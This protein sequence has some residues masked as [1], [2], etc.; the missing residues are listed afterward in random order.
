M[1]LWQAGGRLWSA[2]DEGSVRE[3][4]MRALELGLNR[5]D[6]A[7]IYGWGRSERLLGSIIGNID[8]VFI[9]SKVGGFRRSENDIVKAAEKIKKRLGRDSVDLLLSHWPP[10]FYADICRVI[11]GLEKAVDKGYARSIGVSNYPYS[12]LEKAV[13]CTRK[14][15][16]K[17]DQVQYSLAYRTPELAIIPR[18]K[19]LNITVMAWSPLAKGAL[20]ASTR[21]REPARMS[22][23]VYRKVAND[24]CLHTV[25]E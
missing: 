20:V 19:E 22:D 18:A 17:T 6:T 8:E 9:V 10:P 23:P 25:L 5:F 15:E 13:Y 1:G 21:R 2:T 16:V 7:E 4:I 3:A 14:Y 12:L 11:H 24:K